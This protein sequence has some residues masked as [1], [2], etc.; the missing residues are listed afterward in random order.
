MITHDE[1][2]DYLSKL[3]YTEFRDIVYNYSISAKTDFEKEL[4]AMVTLNFQNRL[5]KLGINKVCP[6]C[7]SPSIKKYGF[8]NRTQIFKCKSCSTK[9]SLF[10][11]TILENTKWHWDIWVVV[12][13]M[14]INGYSVEAMVYVLK[15]DFGCVG[16]NHKTVWLWRMKLIHA[17][18]AMPMPILS[19]VV[20]IMKHLLGSRR[21][22]LGSL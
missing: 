14:I 10:T 16:I 3:A 4:D 18:A 22:A 2:T 20:Q 1:V 12:L 8:R 7:G 13:G 5:E 9:F 19:G 15:N 21:K 17:I 6:K 11:N